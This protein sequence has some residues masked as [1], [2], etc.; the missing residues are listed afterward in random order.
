MVAIDSASPVP[1][2]F[3]L[4]EIL[5]EEIE[6]EE[7]GP[8]APIPSERELGRRHGL[9]RMTVRQA[10]ERL[11]S[12][13]RLSRVPGKGTFVSRPKISMAVRLTS[14]TDDMRARGMQPGARDLTRQVIRATAHLARNL[15]LVPGAEVHLI[16]RV[17]LADGEP[18]AIERSHI[19][20]VLAPGLT[21]MP[22][23]GRSLYQVLEEQFGIVLDEGEQTI[24]A[25]IV[26]PADASVLEI[27]RD[28]AVLHM[29]R[30]SSAGGGWVE[31]AVSTYRADRY[32]LHSVL[33]NPRRLSR[34]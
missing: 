5:L 15:G 17:R 7:L 22:L 26:D 23:S 6:E 4:R 31:L 33:E 10:I 9:S 1:K 16:E 34:E 2:Y 12:E 8:G 24:G 28:S 13:G 29:Q 14:F 27:P 19:P 18:M 3:Q 11:V 30:R 21:D 25:G 20:A 32:Q